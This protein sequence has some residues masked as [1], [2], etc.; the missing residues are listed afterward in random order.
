MRST[1]ASVGLEQRFR[2]G[3]S[4]S[5]AV[6]Q[7][8]LSIGC[9]D[10]SIIIGFITVLSADTSLLNRRGNRRG[11][12]LEVDVEVESKV[13]F[14]D[15]SQARFVVTERKVRTSKGYGRAVT[16]NKMVKDKII[17]IIFSGFILT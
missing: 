5:G 15:F 2:E 7:P 11:H 9:S 6:L 16:G 4:A 14:L 3:N 8:L 12:V 17:H 10:F 13:L 1:L